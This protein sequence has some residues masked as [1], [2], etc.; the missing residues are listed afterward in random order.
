M[1]RMMR[2]L[3]ESQQQSGGGTVEYDATVQSE[4]SWGVGM[5]WI[6]EVKLVL[7]SECISEYFSGLLL[8]RSPSSTIPLLRSHIG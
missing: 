4:R 1:R 8:T 2:I 6:L 3:L 7:I 5:C